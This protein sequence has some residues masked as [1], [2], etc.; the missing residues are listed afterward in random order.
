MIGG[1]VLEVYKDW[2]KVRTN[3]MERVL[4]MTGDIPQRG[5]YI[6]LTKRGKSP[7]KGEEILVSEGVTPPLWIIV[8]AWKVTKIKGEKLEIVSRAIDQISK[9]I[10]K[11]PSWFIRVLKDYYR[12]GES[13]P[14]RKVV[15]SKVV[16]DVLNREQTKLPERESFGDW[17]NTLSHPYGFRVYRGKGF[18]LR[19][20]F[21]KREGVEFQAEAIFQSGKRVNFKGFL[22]DDRITLKL[23]GD[24]EDRHLESLRGRFLKLF[25]EVFVTRGGFE[26]GVYV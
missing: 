5:W 14:R 17:F 11:L 9:K 18:I 26:S 7:F 1:W 8:E 25:K 13:F 6:R 24:F 10:G 16:A 21:E 3:N 22:S 19:I 23:E 20:F 4:K 15:T 12:K 2:I